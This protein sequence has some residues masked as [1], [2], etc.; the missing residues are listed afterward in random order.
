MLSGVLF[1]TLT[2]V[3]YAAENKADPLFEIKPFRRH[4]ETVVNVKKRT[5]DSIYQAVAR[6]DAAGVDS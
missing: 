3:A 1:F 2:T 6:F 4:Y 5:P